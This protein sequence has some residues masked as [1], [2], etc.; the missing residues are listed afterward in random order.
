MGRKRLRQESVNLSQRK[1]SMNQRL[2]PF[3]FADRF[4]NAVTVGYFYADL[5]RMK[6]HAAIYRSLP[7]NPGGEEELPNEYYED[8]LVEDER[9]VA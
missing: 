8:A 1:T 4:L 5:E 3:N 7:P 9:Y 2:N 6:R